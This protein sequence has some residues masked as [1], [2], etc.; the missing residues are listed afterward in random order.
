MQIQRTH[1]IKVHQNGN[2]HFRRFYQVKMGFANVPVSF[3]M[4]PTADH[5]IPE[6]EV[7]ECAGLV[8]D[9]WHNR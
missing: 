9:S 2:V 7:V 5:V 1:T 4:L 6:S 3:D 8:L